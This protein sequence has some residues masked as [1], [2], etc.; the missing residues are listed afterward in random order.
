M[1]VVDNS[2]TPEPLAHTART[3][4]DAV[5]EATN[6]AKRCVP[7]IAESLQKTENSHFV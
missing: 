7:V 5:A 6:T 4:A 1:P 3:V 2:K